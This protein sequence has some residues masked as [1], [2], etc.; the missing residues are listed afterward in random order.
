MSEPKAELSQFV[1]NTR[2][3]WVDKAGDRVAVFCDPDR[4][5]LAFESIELRVRHDAALFDIDDADRVI[6]AIR[7][8]T[9]AER[10][11]RSGEEPASLDRPALL[12]RFWRQNQRAFGSPALL[13]RSVRL[14]VLEGGAA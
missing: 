6:A 1:T 4:T 3:E 11:E 10:A 5:V 12:T 8:V 2:V 13:P 7:T 14:I 9:N